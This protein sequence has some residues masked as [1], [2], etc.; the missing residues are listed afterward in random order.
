[1]E[2]SFTSSYL[3]VN[4]SLIDINR[5]TSSKL[6]NSENQNEKEGFPLLI[7]HSFDNEFSYLGLYGSTSK[8]LLIKVFLL[9]YSSL[10]NSKSSS[11]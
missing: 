4:V 10:V 3:T 5:L 7:H 2:H 11:G 8:Q 9:I 1:M 6:E